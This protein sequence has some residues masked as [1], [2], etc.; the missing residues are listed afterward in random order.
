MRKILDEIGVRLYAF[1]HIADY[2]RQCV[3]AFL[4]LICSMLILYY[5]FVTEV[6]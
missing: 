3:L 5:I 2:R 1:R 6:F 4:L